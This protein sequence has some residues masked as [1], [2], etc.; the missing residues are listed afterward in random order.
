M[1]SSQFS[2][3]D[4]YL[5]GPRVKN[6]IIS[7]RAKRATKTVKTISRP[8]VRLGFD[9]QNLY[10]AALLAVGNVGLGGLVGTGVVA[11]VADSKLFNWDGKIIRFSSTTTSARFIVMPDNLLPFL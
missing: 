6:C 2:N 8:H 7:W 5:L 9:P 11:L 3:S 1:I 10:V 4:K